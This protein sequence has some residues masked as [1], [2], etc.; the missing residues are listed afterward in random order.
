MDLK[1]SV[2]VQRV[3]TV[4]IQANS[5]LHLDEADFLRTGLRETIMRSLSVSV[6][7]IGLTPAAF[8]FA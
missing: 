7:I 6:R 5:W 1:A 4:T 8:A 2:N 3:I